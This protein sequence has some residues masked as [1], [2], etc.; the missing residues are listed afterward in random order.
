MT[1][2]SLRLFASRILGVIRLDSATFEKIEH[3]DNATLP[4]IIIASLGGVS[5]GIGAAVPGFINSDD[6]GIGV[7]SS[8]VVFYMILGLVGLLLF[9]SVSLIMGS[10]VF[11]TT[12][13]DSSW[14]ELLRVLGYAGTPLVLLGWL[15]PGNVYLMLLV[16]G[17]FLATVVVALRQALDFNT[18]RAIATAV[19]SA[20]ILGGVFM[21]L[22]Y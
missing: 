9:T 22:T 11:R 19:V 7:V 16:M 3:D 10:L 18:L 2:L 1:N 6:S 8:F 21:V 20:S 17:C 15:T 13:T 4:A 12:A 5:V 14:T